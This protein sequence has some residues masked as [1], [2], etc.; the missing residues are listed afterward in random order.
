MAGRRLAGVAKQV[1]DFGAAAVGDVLIHGGKVGGGGLDHT[2]H[3]AMQVLSCSRL[4]AAFEQ[5]G[6]FGTQGGDFTL[7][8]LQAAVAALVQH[9]QRVDGAIEGQLAPQ[10]RKYFGAPVVGNAGGV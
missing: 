3:F 1:A 10:A 2:L 4:A 5:I 7:M 9:G 8:C 6:Q